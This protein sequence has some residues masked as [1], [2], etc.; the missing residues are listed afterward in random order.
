MGVLDA[1][2][3]RVSLTSTTYDVERDGR[4]RPGMGYGDLPGGP[5]LILRGDIEAALY[6]TVAPPHGDP[7]RHHTHRP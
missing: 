4:R 5:R 3:N 6:D 7:L 2:G 1:I